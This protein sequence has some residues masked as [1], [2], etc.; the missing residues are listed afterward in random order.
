V[1]GVTLAALLI[2]IGAAVLVAQ[3]TDLDIGPRG[4]FG[5]ALLV[6]GIGL[7]VSAVTGA[8][9]GAKGGLIAL[10]AVLSLATVLASTVDFSAGPHGPV[11]DRT[12]RPADAA[13]V[14]TVYDGGMGDM[15]L[16]L[17][18]IDPADLDQTVVTEIQ[19]GVG[20]ISVVVPRD[21]D[22]QVSAMTGAGDLRFDGET[23]GEDATL[24]PGT[25]SG[26]WVD[27]GRAEFRITVHNGLGDVEVSRG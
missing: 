18:R 11:G 7:V 26:T 4:F 8:G 1:P 16:D 9:R 24:H 27:D 22:V 19:H 5:T 14:H 13:A 2:V 17:T 20:D 23:I 12:Y 6:V 10:G 3:F 21:A 15:V 25:G